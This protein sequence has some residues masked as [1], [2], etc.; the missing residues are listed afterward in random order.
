M[1]DHSYRNRS[2]AETYLRRA[3][4]AA[5]AA[6]LLATAPAAWAQLQAPAIWADWQEV[7][8]RLGATLEAAS[9]TYEGG[10]LTLDGITYTSTLSGGTGTSTFDTVVMTERPDGGVDIILPATIETESLSEAE[11]A[12]VDQTW[13]MS[14]ENLSI[15]ARETDGERTYDIAADTVTVAVETVMDVD[16]TA[17]APNTTTVHMTGLDSDYVSGLAPEGQGFRQTYAVASMNIAT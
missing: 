3:R 2:D 12:E 5:A 17:T 14:H 6:L 16:G 4:L 9:Q 11:E 8:A 1:R 15:V 13:R 7:S 10:T